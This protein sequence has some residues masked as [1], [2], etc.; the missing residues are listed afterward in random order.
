MEIKA[1]T[2]VSIVKNPDDPEV[3]LGPQ[4]TPRVFPTPKVANKWIK[5]HIK[6]PKERRELHLVKAL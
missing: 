2:P 5:K 4:G 6:S 3:M 1:D